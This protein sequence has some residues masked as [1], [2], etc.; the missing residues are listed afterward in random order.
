MP[1]DRQKSLLKMLL[2]A[3]LY[4]VTGRLGQYF[5]LPPG[6]I[7]AI[8]LPSGIALAGMLVWGYSVWPG[9]AVGSFFIGFGAFFRDVSLQN[10]PISLWLGMGQCLG[11]TLQALVGAWLVRRY[12]ERSN[13]LDLPS[14]VFRFTAISVTSCLIC[15]TM[16]VGSLCIAGVLPWKFSGESWF[17]WWLGDTAGILIVVPYCLVEWGQIWRRMQKKTVAETLFLFVLLIFACQSLFGSW[18]SF[19]LENYPLAFFPTLLLIWIIFRVGRLGGIFGASLI[20]VLALAGMVRGEGPFNDVPLSTGVMVLQIY[21]GVT[22]V[23]GLFVSASL[24]EG[25]RIQNELFSERESL[26]RK[27]QELETILQVQP[28]KYYWLDSDGIILRQHPKSKNRDS[29]P[30]LAGKRVSDVLTP[31]FS[32]QFQKSIRQVIE[33]SVPDKIE[34][35]ISENGTPRFHEARLFPLAQKQALVVVRDITERQSAERDLRERARLA[36]FAGE[37]GS[38]LT[39]GGIPRCAC[40][41]A[42]TMRLV[43][44]KCARVMVDRLEAASSRIW[45]V[46]RADNVLEL[47]GYAG[48]EPNPDGSENRIPLGQSLIGLVAQSAKPHITNYVASDFLVSHLYGAKGMTA[49]AGYPLMVQGRV[50]GVMTLFTHNALSQTT[51]EALPPV[52]SSVAL[53]IEQQWNWEGMQKAKDAAEEANRAKSEF[54]A[55]MSHEIRTPMNGILGMAEL[56][57]DTDLSAEQK[58]FIE[59]IQLSAESLLTIINA[60]LDASR[61]EA[62]K[63]D[64]DPFDFTLRKNLADMCKPL[65]IRAHKKGLEF[66]YEVAPGVPDNLHGDW[67]RLRQVLVNLIGNALKFTLHGEVLV[68]L[69]DEEKQEDGVLIHFSVRDTGIGVASESMKSIFAPF[70]QADGSMTRR[71]GGTGLGLAICQQL[72]EMMGGKIWVESELERGSTFHFTA[73][74]QVVPE[75]SALDE[76]PQGDLSRGESSLH[77][78]SNQLKGK[79][80]L[81]VDDNATSLRILKE[82]LSGWDMTPLPVGSGEAA[83][84]ELERRSGLEGAVDLILLDSKMPDMSGLDLMARIR[85]MP[86]WAQTPTFVLTRDDRQEIEQEAMK[87]GVVGFL[88]KPVSPSDLLEGIQ[89]VLLHPGK[90]QPAP[91]VPTGLGRKAADLPSLRILLVED[92]FF[93]R[94]IAVVLLER[95]G[96]KVRVAE[97]GRDALP[98]LE[99]EVFDLV[100]MD[101]QM[102]EMDGMEATGAIRLREKTSGGHIPII[103]LT[104]HAMKGDKERFLEAGMDGYVTKPIRLEELWEAIRQVVPGIMSDRDA[105]TSMESGPALNTTDS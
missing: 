11:A 55:N 59:A 86:R 29:N 89:Q 40:F 35:P 85:S 10:L 103:A 52:A 54:L 39:A 38:A 27:T 92:N 25:Q 47:F 83:L 23:T 64:L 58:E 63:L 26:K 81:A 42:Q 20:F 9:I 65:A 60:I 67:N 31:D 43:L 24:G 93:N 90:S 105:R 34:Y 36:T 6:T 3:V 96:H 21:M 95:N 61:I 87:L 102:P 71:F 77:L 62:G 44:D 80:V 100:L 51:L 16:G 18:L 50:V 15:C 1:S 22:M 82:L 70:V 13:P 57:L 69:F 8:W 37:V 56:A 78:P 49:F 19:G 32:E 79:T 41:V 28:D 98:I 91:Q 99:R 17:T 53:G 73:R 66:A 48:L 84:L 14:D 88:A 33:T 75:K 76:N 97:N 2:L 7:T 101:V 12:C 4:F 30:N 74:V 94:R 104:A 45:V 68:S 5:A 46:D 72:V